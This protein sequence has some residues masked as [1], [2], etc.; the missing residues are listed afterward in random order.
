MIGDGTG[1]GGDEAAP[2]LG[3]AIHNSGEGGGEGKG[4]KRGRRGR[5]RKGGKRGRRGKVHFEEDWVEPFGFSIC[6][7]V[8]LSALRLGLSVCSHRLRKHNAHEAISYTGTEEGRN[9]G[10]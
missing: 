10:R 9:T 3:G 7:S 4:G 1:E 5:G 6:L 2:I 8:C